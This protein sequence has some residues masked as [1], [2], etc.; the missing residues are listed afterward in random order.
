MVDVGEKPAT[1]RRATARAVV[2]FPRPCVSALLDGRG[3]K[4]PITE[5]ARAA[6]VLAAKRTSDW[7]PLCHPLALSHVDVEFHARGERRIEIVCT[8]AC[9]GPTGVE[10]EALVGVAVAALTVYDMTK[11]LDKG[12]VIE[13]LELAE[14]LGGKSGVWRR[15]GRSRTRRSSRA[16]APSP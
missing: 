3:P 4:G 10:M 16:A 15:R 8:A 6:A 5:V 11:A 14:K 9:V 12:I 7:I 2:R 1:A 13:S